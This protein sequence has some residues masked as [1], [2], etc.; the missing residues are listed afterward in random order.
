MKNKICELLEKNRQNTKNGSLPTYI[1][2]LIKT[3]PE[4]LGIYISK[5]NG[6]EFGCG[7][8]K[9]KF[10][11][12]SISKVIT[13]MLALEDNGE[14]FVFSKVGM[15]PTG[16][17]FNSM[18]KLEIVTPSKPFNP[19]INAG[20][21]AVTSMIKGISSKEKWDRIL[22]FLRK[23]TCN[24]NLDINKSVYI[25]EK[26]TGD[27]NR[28]LAY[29]LK[30]VGII[31][32][33][34]EDQ[35]NVYFMQCSIEVDCCDI[36]RIASFIANNGIIP[37]SGEKLVSKKNAIIAKTF[38]L[39]CGMYDGSGEFAINAGIPAKSGVGGGIMAVVPNN[40][41]IGVIGPALDIKGNSIAGVKLLSDISKEFDLSIF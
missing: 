32:G 2:E 33:D 12:Q 11:M 4:I 30:D 13:L 34:A 6:E 26:S 9:H 3:D 17:S 25:S 23:I 5:L 37:S 28:A 22:D 19:M 14:K 41:G 39:T 21:I 29:F 20:A 15:E 24:P 35:L 16:D 40:L 7:N 18:M 27:K 8:Y 1:P 38:M 31:V 36:A 10:T